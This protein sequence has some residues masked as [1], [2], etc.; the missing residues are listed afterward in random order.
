MVRELNRL[1][2][3]GQGDGIGRLLVIIGRQN[4]PSRLSLPSAFW[5]RF[6][7]QVNGERPFAGGTGGSPFGSD[8]SAG[9]R[10]GRCRSGLCRFGV[11]L[12]QT[13]GQRLVLR[14]YRC[15][16]LRLGFLL[17]PLEAHHETP[18]GGLVHPLGLGSSP[19]FRHCEKRV[20]L[21]PQQNQRNDL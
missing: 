14:V 10:V 15:R 19:V 21:D 7:I 6:G 1:R 16:T 2:W 3:T 20:R 5:G 12:T 13:V 18:F 11:K 9:R 8:A 4:S 17:L